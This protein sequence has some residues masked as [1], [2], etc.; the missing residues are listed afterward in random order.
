MSYVSV[1]KN[2]PEFLSQPAGIAAIASVGI[3]GAIAFIL[4][5]M[6]VDRKVNQEASPKSVGVM[7][8][9]EAEQSR[10]PQNNSPKVAALPQVPL[11]SAIPL[12]NFAVQPTPL[13]IIPPSPDSTKVIIPSLPQSSVNPNI[14]SSPR[15]QPLP[16]LRQPN[17]DSSFNVKAKSD[18]SYRRFNQNIELGQS[19]P[20]ASR[21]RNAAPVTSAPYN[22]PDI[23]PLQ[24][25][26][27][28][29]ELAGIP[30]PP[31]LPP[32]SGN[33]MLA[34]NPQINPDIN[35]N[36][37]VTQPRAVNPEDFIAPV[38]R[39]IPQPGDNLTLAG[40]SLQQWGQEQSAPRKIELPNQPSSPADQNTNQDTNISPQDTRT[41]TLAKQFEEVR[42]RYPNSEIKQPISEVIK[43][44]PG[45]EGKIEGTLVIDAE[46]KADYL[47]FVD[48]SVSSDLQKETRNYFRNYFKQNPIRRNG[49]AKVYAFTLDFKSDVTDTARTV[50]FSNPQEKLTDSLRSSKKGEVQINQ[51]PS[52][53]ESKPESISRSSVPVEVDAQQNRSAVVV[54]SVTP[55]P[56]TSKPQAEIRTNKPTSASENND[57]PA[58]E[59]LLRNNQQVPSVPTKPTPQARVNIQ[60][61]APQATSKPSLANRLVNGKESSVSEENDTNTSDSAKKLIQ[62][63]REVKEQREGSK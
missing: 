29:P 12:P 58:V 39:N 52:K 33:D 34:I 54:P 24:S 41:V 37:A 22:L 31:P 53:P 36:G 42:E 23:P 35:S 19:A 49:K 46:G 13:G 9:S 4:P 20:L 15:S 16:I 21:K 60:Q 30:T 55:A 17:F 25:A 8:L 5:L 27:L 56:V 44:K 1:L 3:H 61:P 7:E 59:L 10:L 14:S 11:Q 18:G 2:I 26:P 50:E 47:K 40:Q 51:N 43:T 6:P 48:R 32:T 38:N 63:L 62:R 57:Q 45:K 28:P